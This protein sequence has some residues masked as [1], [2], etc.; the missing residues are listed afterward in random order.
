VTSRGVVLERTDGERGARAHTLEP[1]PLRL[2]HFTDSLDPSGVGEHIALLAGELQACGYQQTLVCP[3][4]PATRWLMER[5][6]GLGLTVEPLHVRSEDDFRDYEALVRLLRDGGYDLCHN[7]IGITWEGCW[8]TFAAADAG[9]PVVCTE[10]LPY[11]IDVPGLHSLKCLA[12][13]HV[14]RTIAVSHGVARSL[15]ESRVVPGDR[16]HV[17]WNGIDVARFSPHR[18]PEL[19]RALLG[20]DL[21][22]PLVVCVGRLTPQKGHAVL[23][24]AIALAR[25]AVPR[26]T[27]ALAG[28][29]P[30]REELLAQATRLGLGEAVRFLG[31]WHDVPP[32]LSCA[33]V[34][35]QPSTFEGLPLAVLEGMAAAVPAVVADVV[36]SNET[37]VPGESGLIVPP[38]APRELAQAIQRILEDP[39]LARR[40][41]TAARRRAE[42]EFTAP[43]MAKRTQAVYARAV[44]APQVVV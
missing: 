37:V 30:L 32:L 34:L 20:L 7:H 27:L 17:V 41:G 16:V 29:G 8:G 42:Q 35:V 19:R 23:L 33:D 1:R 12:G 43:L 24:E 22:T 15:I 28:D 18:R 40:L 3:D 39:A 25:R 36:G 38:N 14:A 31:K 10:H 4:A 5:G 2:L 11:L 9:V 13:H 44:R 6:A 21:Q 26:L